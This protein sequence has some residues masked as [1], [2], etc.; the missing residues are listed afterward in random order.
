MV[1]VSN[2]KTDALAECKTT[3][4]TQFSITFGY[5]A[6]T[7]SFK[8]K[9]NTISYINNQQKHHLNENTESE[10]KR[11]L[12]KNGLDINSTPIFGLNYFVVPVWEM[13]NRTVENYQLKKYFVLITY[14]KY[15]Y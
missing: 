2:K 4:A 14:R 6:F 8:E 12:K 7:Y 10:W 9:D 13:G 11:F 5:A 15:F 1:V 3:R